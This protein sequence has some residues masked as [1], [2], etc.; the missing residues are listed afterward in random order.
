MISA[1]LRIS[2]TL[3][4]PIFA[5]SPFNNSFP[6][7]T[8]KEKCISS[9]FAIK[10]FMLIIKPLKIFTVYSDANNLDVMQKPNFSGVT[11]LQF[12]FY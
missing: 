6:S 12:G 2:L 1:L 5:L 8:A 11:N 10:S 4:L 3:S 9:T 7:S